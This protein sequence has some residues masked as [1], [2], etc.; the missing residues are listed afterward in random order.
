M[1]KTLITLMAAASLLAACDG[2]DNIEN[3]IWINDPDDFCLPKYSEWGY[4]TFGAQMGRSYFVSNWRDIPCSMEWHNEDSTL[5]FTMNG[6]QAFKDEGYGSEYMTFGGNMSLTIIIRCD[7]II[8]GCQKLY[9][10]D[11]K[12][13]DLNA[14]GIT[15][16]VKNKDN[17]PE[18]ITDI[19]SG[20]LFFKRVQMLYV[21]EKFEEAIV[22]GTFDFRY[23]KDGEKTWLSDG[24]FDLGITNKL[25]W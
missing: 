16:L 24:R 15:V 22:S 13:F 7:S 10:L 12:T 23:V 25:F 19:R 4:N 6:R 14:P 5:E 9:M 2:N 8:D 18:P 21:D 1:K 17:L 11:K 3:S 20:E